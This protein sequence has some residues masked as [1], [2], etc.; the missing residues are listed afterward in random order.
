MPVKSAQKAGHRDLEPAPGL[1]DDA[2]NG[3]RREP[4]LVAEK[5][6]RRHEDLLA[7]LG[8]AAGDGRPGRF[9]EARQ[10]IHREA[11][12]VVQT[13]DSPL[14]RIETR[15]HARERVGE[16][17]VRVLPHEGELRIGRERDLV[18]EPFG[19]GSGRAQMVERGTHRGHANP[20]T[21]GPLAGVLGD[22]GRLPRVGHEEVLA[23][24]LLD[25]VDDL[26]TDANPQDVVGNAR[27]EVLFEGGDRRAVALSRAA[28]E[29]E[30]ARMDGV[31]RRRGRHVARE[32]LDE[33]LGRDRDLRPGLAALGHERREPL[34]FDLEP[35]L[36]GEQPSE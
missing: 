6:L 2:R 21:E 17:R 7:S 34:A 19:R 5:G 33:A 24:L 11:L 28:R 1:P 18:A 20:S 10:L 26:A 32:M 14:V 25:V 8:H 36:L 22:L 31:E 29:V 23:E 13:Q 9:V 12:D 30:I 35:C 16:E 27:H 4:A 3:G 15:E